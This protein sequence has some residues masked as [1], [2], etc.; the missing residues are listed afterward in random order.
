MPYLNV[1][2]LRK[3]PYQNSFKT[4]PCISCITVLHV[5]EFANIAQMTA[6]LVVIICSLLHR[7]QGVFSLLV[8]IEIQ[9]DLSNP[10]V[11][12]SISNLMKS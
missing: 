9:H 8:G 3:K 12:M 11:N 10:F 6:T 2:Q 5:K 7:N 4:H 1:L